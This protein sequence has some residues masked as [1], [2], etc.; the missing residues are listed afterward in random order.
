MPI[1]ANRNARM[2]DSLGPHYFT[3]EALRDWTRIGEKHRLRDEQFLR[4][5]EP[6]L[7]PGPI[8][9]IGAATGHLSAI[10]AKR[11]FDITASDVS[12]RFVAAIR[13][14]G[15]RAQIVDAT[16]DI[17][18]QTG[19]TFANVLAQGV[20][21][22]I[23]REPATLNTALAAIHAALE[24]K[25]RLVCICA[26]PWREPSPR[27]YLH[28]QEQIEIA[29]VSGLFHLIKVFPHQVVPPVLYQRWNARV[30]DFL[31]FQAA[32]LASVRLIWVMEK[33]D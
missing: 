22:L 30:L 29:R 3:E 4:H 9:E 10:L 11:G 13:A 17:R 27:F 20:V 14:R 25:G 12:P 19:K 5:L 28:P 33:V 24:S 23:R 26:Y 7:N 16:L 2:N 18:T 1:R 15:L 32:K 21:P 6:L 8:L 31:D